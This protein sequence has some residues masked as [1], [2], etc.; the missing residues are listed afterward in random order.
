MPVGVDVT[1]LYKALASLTLQQR[2]QASVA[3][4][5]IFRVGD[6]RRSLGEQFLFGVAEHLAERSVCP[7]VTVFEVEQGHADGS[8]FEEASELRLAL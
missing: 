7:Q 4:P 8:I 5:P 2:L 1:L 6:L 3:D